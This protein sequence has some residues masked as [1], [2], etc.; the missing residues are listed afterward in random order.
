MNNEEAHIKIITFI[1]RLEKIGV[2]VMLGANFPWIYL[3]H[4]NGKRVKEKFRAEHG[5]TIGFLPIRKGQNFEFTDIA[6]IFKLIR[7]YR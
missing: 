2:D 6:E 4:I 7:K 3:T 5:F 1:R